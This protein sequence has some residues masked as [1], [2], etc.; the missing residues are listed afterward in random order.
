[1]AKGRKGLR[2][3]MKVIKLMEGRGLIEVEGV[4]RF[5]SLWVYKFMG[6]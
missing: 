3:L 6:L 1:V 2:E 4:Y 5:I